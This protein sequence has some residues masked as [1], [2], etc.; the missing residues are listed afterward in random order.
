MEGSSGSLDFQIE[1]YSSYLE[2]DSA[3]VPF[4]V[5]LVGL[6]GAL[7]GWKENL[8]KGKLA[9]PQAAERDRFFQQWGREAEKFFLDLQET[10][11]PWV[12]FFQIG[13]KEIKAHSL[14]PLED[15]YAFYKEIQL[16]PGRIYHANYANYH[17][18][19]QNAIDYDSPL[20]AFSSANQLYI[21]D[22][23]RRVAVSL[24]Q[25]FETV[26]DGGD[27]RLLSNF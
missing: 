3:G 13:S 16:F 15:G 17:Q 18:V 9:L 8:P 22:T 21:G 10:H 24:N 14:R 5:R 26:A 6:I 25:L 4:P 23:S 11:E 27:L 19:P 12:C 7:K 2:R 20:G 1:R